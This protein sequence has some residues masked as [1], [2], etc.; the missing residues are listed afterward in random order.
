M[1]TLH[2][3]KIGDQNYFHILFIVQTSQR[4]NVLFYYKIKQ[5]V[6]MCGGGGVCMGGGCLEIWDTSSSGTYTFYIG[7]YGVRVV[8]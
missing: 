8:G 7:F 2:G 3:K 6:C 1:S 4:S 5:C